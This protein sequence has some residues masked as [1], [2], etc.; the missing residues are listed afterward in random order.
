MHL[1]KKEILIVL[2]LIFIIII[3]NY[4]YYEPSVFIAKNQGTVL[5]DNWWDALNWIKNNTKECAVIATYWDPGHFITGI[6]RRPV[7]FDGAS[8]NE[9]LTIEENGTNITRAR[10]QD[11]ATTLFTDNETKAIG[12]LKDYLIC[13]EMYYIASADLIAK[14]QWW[15]YF[16]TWNPID[17]GNMYV[18]R[19]S[20]LIEA[21]PLIREDAISYSYYAGRDELGQ[22]HFYVIYEKA[23]TL[24]PTYQAGNNF[25]KI[26][27][28]VNMD[29]GMAWEN[30]DAEVLGTILL[31]N[32][33][34]LLIHIPEELENSMFTR[35]FFFNGEGLK[36]FE[37]V[38][39]W[40][41]EVKLFKVLFD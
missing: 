37:F 33:K 25:F 15:T 6:A 29:D 2:V 24:I 18:Y 8:Q 41:G 3:M 27:K 13:D 34:Q 40:G 21:K 32:R 31:F 20:N 17:Y 5:S 39:N 9:V 16:S 14:S 10:I 19:Q 12:I 36:H 1:G 35:M 30:E 11:I 38:R 28:L 22:D 4:F 7:V 23:G 26:K